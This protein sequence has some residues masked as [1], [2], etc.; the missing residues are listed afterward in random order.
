MFNDINNIHRKMG[1][2]INNYLKSKC[3]ESI[4]ARNLNYYSKKRLAI[5]VSMFIYQSLHAYEDGHVQGIFNFISKLMRFKIIPIIVFD[6]CPGSEKDNTLR[7]RRLIKENSKQKIIQL[8]QEIENLYSESSYLEGSGDSNSDIEER[9]EILTRKIKKLKQKCIEIKHEHIYDIKFMLNLLNISYVHVYNSEAD[10][11]CSELV[12]HGLADGVISNDMDLIAYR[13][14]MVIRDFNFK[15]ETV[16]EYNV[17]DICKNLQIT[18]KQ[19]TDLCIMCGTDYNS[20]IGYFDE[21]ELLSMLK[22]N[23][24]IEKLIESAKDKN[25]KISTKF[26]HEKSQQIF[27]S[28]IELGDIKIHKNEWMSDREQVFSYLIN[29]CP[30]LKSKSVHKKLDLILGKTYRC[31]QKKKNVFNRRKE[32]I[33]RFHCIE[34]I[35]IC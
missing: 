2:P 32:F 4:K 21:N 10:V 22:D 29:K 9:R 13:C 33:N 27:N 19:L 17:S 30:K 5:D 35:L 23:M 6:G 34:P 7:K 20:R 1:I 28:I 24:S 15:L 31:K 26:N 12:R 14:P 11:V 18:Q 25:I 16:V 3:C 8:E